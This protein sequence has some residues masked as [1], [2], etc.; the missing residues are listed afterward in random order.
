[1][2]RLIRVKN[3]NSTDSWEGQT[4]APGEYY[5]LDETEHKRWGD[6]QKVNG[7]VANGTL[8]V[9]NGADTV[10][11]FS[12]PIAGWKW[13]TGDTMPP[14]SSD[15][16]WHVVN[17]NFAHVSGNYGINWTV[18]CEL[19]NDESYQEKLIL[20]AGRH[21]TLNILRGGSDRVP[22]SILLEWYEELTVDVYMR[23]NPW[24]RADE[25]IAGVIN[26]AH[27]TN[28]TVIT[29]YNTNNDIDWIMADHYYCFAHTSGGFHAKVISVDIPNSQF[30]LEAGIPVGLNN[31]D[32]IALTDRPIGRI[33]SQIASDS[34][35]WTSPPNG[36]IGN[37]K[38]YF[39]LTMTNDDDEDVGLINATLNGWHTAT[40]GGD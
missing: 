27:A 3:T 25:Q 1:M 21:A 6:S 38:N 7:S 14:Q 30:T 33:G 16:D 39:L 2:A 4:I 40:N 18:E 37:D 28:D 22:S 23:V 17:E 29:I 35:A 36:F 24:V 34:L 15:G 5:T 8:I 19:E 31:G 12:D 11:D 26:G 10:D 13:L 9:N 20:P 32:K